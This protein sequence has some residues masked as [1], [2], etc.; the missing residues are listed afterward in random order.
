MTIG[1]ARGASGGG[2]GGAGPFS[3]KKYPIWPL[4]ATQVLT[5]R[6]ALENDFAFFKDILVETKCREYNGHNTRTCREAGMDTKPNTEVAF[7]P[8]VNR[9][10]AMM[11]EKDAMREHRA[12]HPSIAHRVRKGSWTSYALFRGLLLGRTLCF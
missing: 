2:G 7:L 11:A 3:I 9:P 6:R 5:A 4:L 10:P 12:S 8:L 1:V